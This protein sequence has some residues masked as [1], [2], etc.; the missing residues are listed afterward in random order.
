MNTDG[1]EIAAVS[2]HG[3]DN[4]FREMFPIVRFMGR[5]LIELLALAITLIGIAGFAAGSSYTAGWNHAAGISSNLFPIGTNE[6]ILMGLTLTRPWLYSGSAFALLVIYI[7]LLEILGEWGDA[8]RRDRRTWR[9][10]LRKN[11]DS[12]MCSERVESEFESRRT[13]NPNPLWF[14]FAIQKRRGEGKHP[15]ASKKRRFRKVFMRLGAMGVALSLMI[16]VSVFYLALKLFIIDMAH[17]QGAEKYVGLYLAVTG[18]V[19]AQIEIEFKPERLQELACIG[20][21]DRWFYRSIDL[22]KDGTNPAYVIQSTDKFFLLLDKGGSSLHSFGD[23]AFSLLESKA[24]PLSTLG[25]NC[26]QIAKNKSS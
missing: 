21:E 16:I 4:E 6:T 23:A 19:P 9:Y 26:K 2:A 8:R 3:Q 20:E 10:R 13:D 22:L 14:A 18:K 7:H 11:I 25:Q 24:R 1:K 15:L 12:A 5:H 17:K